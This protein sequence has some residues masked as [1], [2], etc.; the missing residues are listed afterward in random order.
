[1]RLY[2][3]SFTEIPSHWHRSIE[4]DLILKGN[5]TLLTNDRII[6]LK[7]DDIYLINKNVVHEFKSEAGCAFVSLAID[8]D[9]VNGFDGD[10]LFSLDSTSTKNSAVFKRMKCYI[11]ELV[12]INGSESND[13]YLLNLSSLYAILHELITNFKASDI[14]ATQAAKHIEKI[15][16]ILRYVEDHY[17]EG[18]TFAEIASAYHYSVPYLSS[19]FKH[20]LGISFQNYYKDFRLERATDELLH[21]DNSIESISSNNGY[22][23][24]RAFVN[25]FKEKYST[26]PSLYRKK[27][28]TPSNKI[29]DIPSD[30]DLYG[31]STM[32]LLSKYLTKE[33]V[34]EESNEFS[35]IK[36]ITEENIDT[37]KRIGILKHNFR[38]F[39]SVGRAKELLLADVQKM[40]TELQS[41]I[42][43]EYIKFHGLL[44]DDML[45][46]SEDENENPIYS[47]V[48]I[49]KM[50]DFLLSI[51]LRPLI[52]FSFMPRDLA[53]SPNRT[54][55]SSPYILSMPKSMKKWTNLIRELTLHLIDRYGFEEVKKW[56]FCCWNEPDTSTNLFGF[57]HDEDYYKLYE[58]TYKTIKEI[59]NR[60][61]FGSPSLLISYSVNQKWCQKYIL[62]CKENDCIPDFM[63]I[64]YYD[65]DFADESFN[66]HKPAKPL[67]S[68]LNKDEN[69]FSKCIVKIK[70]LFGDWG[71]GN[72]P[73][74]LTE[75]NLTVSHRNLLNDTCFKSCYLAKNLLENYDKLDSFGYWVLTDMIEETMP[76]KEQFHGGLGLY[77]T[78][79]IKKPHY[80]VF[81]FLNRLGDSL[82]AKGN[83]YFIARSPN[84]VQIITYNYE[85]F[86]HLF[87]QG[88]TFNMNFLERYTP[89]NKLGPM[90]ISLELCSL[91][92]TSC[93]IK[94][95][96]I[97]QKYGSA[98]DEWIRMGASPMDNDDV[99]YIKNVAVPRRYKRKEKIEGGVLTYNAALDPLEVRY[100]EIDLKK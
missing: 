74:Y 20:H 9:N 60:L 43:Y 83:G 47:F 71:I 38:K 12:K 75:W 59:D 34:K 27:A 6:K 92:A 99:E 24:P 69:S 61:V 33:N 50:I 73:V 28:K 78:S 52:E 31:K 23:N 48:Y 40:L 35:T 4:I 100:V 30:D 62:W 64:H 65:N 3:Y 51:K 26:L 84:K 11:A 16:Q 68:R 49:D 79:G 93:I 86:N 45:V 7:E 22:P 8:L 18:L 89:F 21:T 2:S 29:Q 17:K 72:L 41:E 81:R 57:E 19:F 56:L 94:E 67:H 32:S 58:S 54:V 76:S 15:N 91:D 85:H 77:T 36:L 37:N 44:S 1:M 95:E 5:C 70:N 25:A 53:I 96:I 55:Y 39:I 87:A 82:I 80:Y 46:Y 90:E 42:H 63:N 88:E 10:V 13:N 66:G 97:N 98:F 14:S